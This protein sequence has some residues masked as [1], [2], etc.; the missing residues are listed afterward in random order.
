LFVS[1]TSD[2]DV[3]Q[4]ALSL[5]AQGY[6]LKA[7]VGSE[8]RA[9]VEAVLRD[10]RFGSEGLKHNSVSSPEEKSSEGTSPFPEKGAVTRW[11]EAHFYS[12]DESLLT[13]FTR[14]IETALT[15]GKVSIVIASESHREALL[16][17]L[18]LSGM[19]VSAAI[20]QG[21]CLPLD[22]DEIFSKFMVNDLP[23]PVR[24]FKAVH[25]CITGAAHTGSGEQLR[26]AACGEGTS[27]L[28]AQ[29]KVD[30]AVQLERLWDDIAKTYELDILCG[31]RLGPSQ[32]K[33]E[34]DAY[35]KIC[36]AHSAV[37]SQ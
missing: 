13:G 22:V 18:R 25:E 24:F 17:R 3:V 12:D 26:V 4:E 31:Y 2:P 8:L 11:H 23:D 32:S 27:I 15:A 16:R 34:N 7:H 5:G 37:C 14:F 1:Q 33:Q 35:Q 29:G 36:A 9:A 19:D 30:A 10:E 28:W 21:R 6:V 20:E